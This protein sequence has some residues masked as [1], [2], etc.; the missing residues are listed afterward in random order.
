MKGLLSNIT[1]CHNTANGA[2]C[3]IAQHHY[4]VFRTER[5]PGLD[6]ADNYA[7]EFENPPAVGTVAKVGGHT[8]E[9][10]GG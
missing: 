6:L 1:G 4:L 8:A 7:Y 10:P 9:Y 2:C 3:A 5:F